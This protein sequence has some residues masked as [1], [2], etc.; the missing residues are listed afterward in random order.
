MYKNFDL[1]VKLYTLINLILL[2]GAI[3][4]GAQNRIHPVGVHIYI[5]FVMQVYSIKKQ[6]P[7]PSYL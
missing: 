7:P 3:R 1:I 6:L 4:K 2:H 5:L